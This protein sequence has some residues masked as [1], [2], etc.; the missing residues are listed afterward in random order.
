MSCMKPWPVLLLLLIGMPA[1]AGAESFDPDQ[2]F[3]QALSRQFLEALLNQANAVIQ[4]HLEI[5]GHLGDD[6]GG[7]EPRGSFRFKF[8]PEGKSKSK[9]HF[10]AEGR[11]GPSPDASRQELHFRF[12]LPKSPDSTPQ[13]PDNV[14]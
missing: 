9:E 12:A 1:W 6:R 2:P 4:E 5:T 7:T 3:Q 10:S 13:L 8:Y 11:F 14:L